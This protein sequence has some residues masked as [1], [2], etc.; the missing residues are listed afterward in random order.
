M[1]A[2]ISVFL[3]PNCGEIIPAFDMDESNLS[4]AECPNC[5]KKFELRELMEGLEP[6]IK[7]KKVS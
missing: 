5:K 3:C 1:K 2:S 6:I 7:S 4:L